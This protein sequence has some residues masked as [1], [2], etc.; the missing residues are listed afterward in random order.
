MNTE[1][2]ELYKVLQPLFEEKMGKWQRGD[3]YI[4]VSEVGN[5][6][7]Y[8]SETCSSCE[9]ETTLDRLRVP[10][11]IDDRNPERGLWGMLGDFRE[12]LYC[13]GMWTVYFQPKE[14]GDQNETTASTPTLA[15]LKA[16]VAQGGL[17]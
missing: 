11:T 6:I 9:F 14:L 3:R 15:I 8:F 5:P 17:G 12:L 4:L 2:L 1:Q 16:L 7:L 13:D 10:L